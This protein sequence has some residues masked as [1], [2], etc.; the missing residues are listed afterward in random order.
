MD[1]RRSTRPVRRCHEW[2]SDPASAR[3]GWSPAA[4][5]SRENA[6]ANST[7]LAGRRRGMPIPPIYL[8]RSLAAPLGLSHRFAPEGSS[9]MNRRAKTTSQQGAHSARRVR[10]SGSDVFGN[11]VGERITWIR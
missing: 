10:R 4:A 5:S 11:E 7:A 9:V 8:R 2:P 6:R 3:L 1:R